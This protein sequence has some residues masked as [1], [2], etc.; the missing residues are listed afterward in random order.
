LDDLG[1]G[2]WFDF[3]FEPYQYKPFNRPS[4]ENNYTFAVYLNVSMNSPTF[5]SRFEILFVSNT[6]GKNSCKVSLKS[7]YF[8]GTNE[9]THLRRENGQKR[10]KMQE[11]TVYQVVDGNI[12]H[13]TASNL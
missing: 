8:S 5:L 9:K 12:S 4:I 7:L 3:L 11:R 2:K 13:T 6:A 1:T 10:K